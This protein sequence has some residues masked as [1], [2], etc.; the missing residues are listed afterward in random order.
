MGI[1][2]ADLVKALKRLSKQDREVFL[3]NLLA[4]TSPKYLDSI[5]EAREDY[6]KGRVSSHSEA[7]RGKKKK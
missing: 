3:E 4:A 7:F 2:F 1:R 6:K 5:K